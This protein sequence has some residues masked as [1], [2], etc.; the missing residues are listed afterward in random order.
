MMGGLP[1]VTKGGILEPGFVV[2]TGFSV[3]F[4]MPAI[5]VVTGGVV[6]RLLFAPG[7]KS[8]DELEG[9]ETV[10]PNPGVTEA[11]VVVVV[12]G[13]IVVDPGGIV[14]RLLFI[15]GA[16]VV[17]VVEVIVVVVTVVGGIVVAGNTAVISIS[18]YANYSFHHSFLPF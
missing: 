12:V 8:V 7:G 6:G 15:S 13:V 1:V 11:A 17:E 16:V 5:L 18:H 2:V 4:V 14:G 10:V 3:V 9:F